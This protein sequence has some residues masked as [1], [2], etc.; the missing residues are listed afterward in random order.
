MKLKIETWPIGKV[1]P[2]AKNARLHSESQVEA[3]A[4]SI[5]EFGFV[6]PCLVDADGVLIAGHGRVLA[7]KKRRPATTASISEPAHGGLN[8]P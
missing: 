5:T 8:A 2:Y 7:A 6:N 1:L 3:L 4:K